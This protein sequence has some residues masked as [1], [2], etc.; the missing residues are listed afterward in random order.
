MQDKVVVGRTLHGVPVA[1]YHPA[2]QSACM[3]LGEF[4]CII[5]YLL[6]RWRTW[7]GKQR[8]EDETTHGSYYDATEPLLHGGHVSQRD[9]RSM[10][11]TDH[12]PYYSEGRDSADISDSVFMLALPTLCDA[13]STTLMN[14]GLYYTSASTFQMLR[15]LVVFFAGV[16]SVVLRTCAKHLSFVACM[17]RFPCCPSHHRGFIVLP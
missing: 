8:Q 15:G 11:P 13:A 1:F 3:F 5:P 17:Q 14:I 6:Q 2:V 10:S 9:R 4:L 16:T 12:V 7:S